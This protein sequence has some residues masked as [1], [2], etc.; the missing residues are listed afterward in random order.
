MKFELKT[1]EMWELCFSTLFSVNVFLL[2]SCVWRIHG[3]LS[4]PRVHEILNFVRIQKNPPEMNFTKYRKKYCVS[5]N[6]AC[7]ICNG[8]YLVQDQKGQ[9]KFVRWER[10][11]IS[12][13]RSSCQY[14]NN[15]RP[16]QITGQYCQY[17]V[18]I[19]SIF[20]IEC[21]ME[22][23]YQLDWIWYVQCSFKLYLQFNF[24]VLSLLLARLKNEIDNLPK[25]WTVNN[26]ERKDKVIVYREFS[27]N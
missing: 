1:S 8:K 27:F 12:S 21:S 18:L 13:F 6:R 24:K 20:W 15:K 3:F 10:Y 5:S 26:L 2:F 9:F 14:Q 17:L 4:T 19:N 7:F 23:R 16:E 11:L 25:K 22:L